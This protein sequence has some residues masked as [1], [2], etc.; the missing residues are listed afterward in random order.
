ERHM[1]ALAIAAVAFAL[2]ATASR[3]AVI[4]G[5]KPFSL[6]FATA[7]ASTIMILSL[8]AVAFHRRCVRTTSQVAAVLAMFTIAVICQTGDRPGGW[9]CA[10]ESAVQ[11]HAL[12]HVLSAIT[13]C[14]S[15]RIIDP[16]TETLHRVTASLQP[17]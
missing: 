10:P 15:V 2:G 16:P 6:T 12:W 13:I 17:P 5:V 11:A 4:F 14:L 3:D 1:G 9:L 8:M 7:M